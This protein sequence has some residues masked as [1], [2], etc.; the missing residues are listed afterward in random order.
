MKLVNYA[1]SETLL[2]N[3]LARDPRASLDEIR[4]SHP[5]FKAMSLDHLSLRIG[6]LLDRTA[7]A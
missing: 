2:R 5:I 7:W 6:R 1:G 4:R 3:I